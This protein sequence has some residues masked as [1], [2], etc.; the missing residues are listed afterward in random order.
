VSKPV[1]LKA[2]CPHC[3]T[4]D[5][6]FSFTG[7]YTHEHKDQSGNVLDTVLFRCNGCSGPMAATVLRA[8]AEP[9]WTRTIQ[10]VRDYRT[11]PYRVLELIPKEFKA[12]DAPKHTPPSIASYYN[13]A[14]RA[15][16]RGDWDAAGMAFRKALDISTKLLIRNINPSDLSA[17]LADNLYKRIEWLHAQGK[18]TPELKDWAHVIRGE[19]NDAAHEEQPYTK[20]EAEQVHNFTQVFLMYIFTIPGMIAVYK[21]QPTP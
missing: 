11:S 18:L 12:D 1:T 20:K 19:G 9:V 3:R 15:L 5:Q 17:R 4:V 10:L 7:G 14:C 8:A 6:A 2:N 21:T 16:E 13:Q